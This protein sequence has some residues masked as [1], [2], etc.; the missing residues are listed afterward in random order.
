MRSFRA[1]VRLSPCCG[2]CSAGALMPH[3]VGAAPVKRYKIAVIQGDL[4]LLQKLEF[5]SRVTVKSYSTRDG[6]YPTCSYCSAVSSCPI[7]L[8][9]HLQHLKQM[10]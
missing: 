2:F 3:L 5:A 8:V 7:S 10:V 9:Q 6:L 4:V 1:S